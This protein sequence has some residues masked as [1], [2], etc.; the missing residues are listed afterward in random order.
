MSHE[1]HALT[2]FLERPVTILGKEHDR[3]D[4]E[5][6]NFDPT[7]APEGKCVVKILLDASYERWKALRDD[8]ER[9]QAEKQQVA[10]QIMDQL[11]PRFPGLK[12]Q[13]EVVDVATP[14]TVERYTGNWRGAQAWL[15]PD[16]GVMEPLMGRSSTLPGL[17]SFHM[18]GQWVSTIGISTAAIGGRKLIK[19]ICKRDGRRFSTIVP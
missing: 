12:E 13:T 6:F 4:V 1:P 8:R 19:K 17:E 5:I 15:A 14:V 9:Y 3:L 11:E 7:M 10:E 18:V 16:A 2:Y